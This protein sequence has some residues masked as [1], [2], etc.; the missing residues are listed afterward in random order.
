MADR[1][2]LERL[3]RSNPGQ[4][5]LEEYELFLNTIRTCAPCNLLVF[6]V[7]RDSPLWIEANEG[8]RTDFLEHEP[9][10]VRET[11]RRI[12]GIRI[13]QVGYRT[14]RTQWKKLLHRRDL[15]FMEDLPNRVLSRRWDVIF[16]DSPQGHRR[17]Q[18]GRMKSIYTASVLARRSGDAHVLVHDC[19]RR[20][21]RAYA[22]AYLGGDHLVRQVAT[23]RH[24]RF[25]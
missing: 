17:K 19:D 21:E 13:H 24:Y 14:R 5:T 7:G 23:L 6:G 18:P 1:E 12:P 25:S 22:D 3:V 10:W 20:V 2:D 9:E 15:L 11:R 4:A 8:G 16:V